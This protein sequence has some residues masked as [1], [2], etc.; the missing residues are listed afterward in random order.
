[1]H[2]LLQTLLEQ[3]LEPDGFVVETL[4][5]DLE[6]LDPGALD[7]PLDRL[8]FLDLLLKCCVRFPQ[9]FFE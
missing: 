1:M 9:L 2:L 3:V 8:E 4:L 5:L 6:L 7:L